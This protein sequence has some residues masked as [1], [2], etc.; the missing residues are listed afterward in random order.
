MISGEEGSNFMNVIEL[1]KAG[2]ENGA[3]VPLEIET[4]A[5]DDLDR[6]FK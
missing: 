6:A 4:F 1:L 5:E 3:V 2:I